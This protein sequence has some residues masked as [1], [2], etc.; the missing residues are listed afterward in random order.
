MTAVVLILLLAIFLLMIFVPTYRTRR[1]EKRASRKRNRPV[2]IPQLNPADRVS[3]EEIWR[4]TF[5]WFHDDP[6]AALGIIDRLAA[7]VLK[8]AGY[9]LSGPA[10][11]PPDTI[12][13][14]YYAAHEITRRYVR[15]E[16]SDID[17][18]EAMLY[19]TS[20]FEQLLHP[21]P[22]SYKKRT[23]A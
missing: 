18:N 15:G 19:Y 16:A 10:Q 23:A 12:V 21:G 2:E 11:A 14:D 3:V 17:L 20:V 9:K 7:E 8:D 22:D 5:S 6:R 13:A 4:S 1:E